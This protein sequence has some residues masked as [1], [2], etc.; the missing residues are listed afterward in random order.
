VSTRP[1]RILQTLFLFLISS[2]IL[3]S[4]RLTCGEVNMQRKLREDKD[5][6]AKFVM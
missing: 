6:L 4:T 3:R 5:Y 2:G 1:D